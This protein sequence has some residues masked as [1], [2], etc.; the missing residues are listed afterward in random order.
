MNSLDLEIC[1]RLLQNCAV[2][3]RASLNAWLCCSELSDKK[4]K[5]RV[6]EYTNLIL[7]TIRTRK[8]TIRYF[9]NIETN[10][11][12]RNN[13]L[14]K[15]DYSFVPRLPSK[16]SQSIAS[17]TTTEVFKAMQKQ[18]GYPIGM[19]LGIQPTTSCS[20]GEQ[21]NAANLGIAC[22]CGAAPHLALTLS[23]PILFPTEHFETYDTY[24][25]ILSKSAM[26]AL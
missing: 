25:T 3:E 26:T 24:S 9:S 20:G 15:Q 17:E 16:S 13:R 7:L 6:G 12:F 18:N 23:A 1:A 11:M 8:L 10:Q 14:V 2:D 22:V 19:L 4:K 21:R 5:I